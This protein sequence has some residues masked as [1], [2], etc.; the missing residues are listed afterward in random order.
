VPATA[1]AT[2]PKEIRDALGRYAELLDSASQ[3]CAQLPGD[4]PTKNDPV[5]LVQDAKRARTAASRVHVTSARND[6]H[7]RQLCANYAAELMRKFSKKRP[8]LSSTGT[9]LKVAE[10]LWAVLTGEADTSALMWHCR[11]RLRSLR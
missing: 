6:G 7:S 4:I 10:L 11:Q 3:V 8:N 5:T 1:I 2:T 9:Y